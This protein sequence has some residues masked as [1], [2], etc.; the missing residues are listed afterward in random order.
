MKNLK[1]ILFGA[2][3]I[4]ALLASPVFALATIRVEPHGSYFGLPIMLTSPATFNVSVTGGAGNPTT[5]PHIFLVMTE[6]SYN[7]LTGN[8]VVNWTGPA[9]VTVTTWHKETNNSVKVP[10]GTDS[11]T[12]YTVAALR[13]HLNTSEPIYWAF[14]GFLTGMD[15]TENP[16]AF[17][18]T[19]PATQPR[20]AVY[21]LGKIPGTAEFNNRSPP[22]QPGFVVPE[23]A[24]IVAATMSIV[25]LV[26]YATIRRK[27]FVKNA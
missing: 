21:V 9:S 23:P 2:V 18:V 3:T 20:M 12:G 11:G 25:A 16:I 26:G 5:D 4:A 22:T 8:V 15:L 14:E 13:D 17:T 27:R 24:T 6:T 1:L 10:P 7:S 19:L